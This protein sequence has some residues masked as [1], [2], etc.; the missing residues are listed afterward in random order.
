MA[1]CIAS[2]VRSG[3]HGDSEIGRDRIAGADDID[4]A[5][6]GDRRDM[7]GSVARQGADDPSSAMLMKTGR[8]VRAASSAAWRCTD[9]RSSRSNPVMRELGGV[10]LETDRR[11]VEQAA[12]AI[13]QD[14]QAGMVRA[15]HERPV[16]PDR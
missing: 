7:L 13:G 10:H 2:Q 14:D 16:A 6:D 15:A 12:A 5:P 1:I 4:R 8:A 11:E 3:G 9:S